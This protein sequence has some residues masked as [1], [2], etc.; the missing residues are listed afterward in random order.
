MIFKTSNIGQW[1]FIGTG[2]NPEIAEY[3]FKVLLRQGKNKR[4]LFIEENL[5][6]CKKASKTRRADLFSEGWCY[7]VT[8]F[9]ES[10]EMNETDQR[11]IECYMKVNYPTVKKSEVTQ[12]N[13]KKTLSEKEENDFFNGW[14]SGQDVKLHRGVSGM[15][16]T[17]QIGLI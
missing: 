6:R 12:R 2:A 5:K 14:L 1:C 11:A 17:I 15:S 16:A 3:S 8:K 7:H 13:N 10:F 9:I 4:A